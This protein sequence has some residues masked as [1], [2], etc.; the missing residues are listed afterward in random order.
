MGLLDMES[1]HSGSAQRP[2]EGILQALANEPFGSMLIA[3]RLNSLLGEDRN[4]PG[5]EGLKSGLTVSV[6]APDL[7]SN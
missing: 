4:P 2:E 7:P 1:G 5:G 3:H 6:T